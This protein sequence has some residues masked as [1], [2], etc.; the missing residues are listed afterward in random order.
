MD[1]DLSHVEAPKRAAFER[2]ANPRVRPMNNAF[3]VT[4]GTVRNRVQWIR[5]IN[6]RLLTLAD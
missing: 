4:L 6:T 1:G 2:G 5:D 3:N